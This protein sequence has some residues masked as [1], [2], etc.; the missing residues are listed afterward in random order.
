MGGA[1]VVGMSPFVRN[2]ITGEAASHLHGVDITP[3]HEDRVH[4][5]T[6]ALEILRRASRVCTTAGLGESTVPYTASL[7]R[8]LDQEHAFKRTQPERQERMTLMHEIA[9]LHIEAGGDLHAT[10]FDGMIERTTQEL[11]DE[12]DRMKKKHLK[13]V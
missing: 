1:S 10:K 4:A 13:P 8:E 11:R 12:L 7:L 9:D 6:E 5:E 2:P 3:T